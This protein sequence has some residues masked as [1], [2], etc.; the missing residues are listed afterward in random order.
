MKDHR[1]DNKTVSTVLKHS[2]D[3]INFSVA[4]QVSIDIVSII[5][6]RKKLKQ[7]QSLSQGMVYL[8]MHY[9]IF[10]KWQT[11]RDRC[12]KISKMFIFEMTNDKNR[13]ICMYGG[14]CHMKNL[15]TGYMC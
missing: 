7:P 15:S 10:C 6:N 14:I 12:R 5:Y 2:S 9:G 13:S 4:S 11:N 8:D 3:K 1:I